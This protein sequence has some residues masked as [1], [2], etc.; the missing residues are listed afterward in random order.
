MTGEELEA[1]REAYE[2]EC[3]TFEWMLDAPEDAPGA[4]KTMWR[5]ASA[6]LDEIERLRAEIRWAI[7]WCNDPSQPEPMV[8]IAALAR[9]VRP[10][11][12][13]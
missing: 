11:E 6:L 9:A 2:G 5:D 4:A 1:I 3:P 12:A 13:E 10:V 7:D 8:A